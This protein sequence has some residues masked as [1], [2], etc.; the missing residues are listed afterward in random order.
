MPSQK[1]Q[2]GQPNIN[3]TSLFNTRTL[4]LPKNIK[5]LIITIPD[6]A[7]HAPNAVP[8]KRYINQTFLPQ[9]AVI[10][11]G[12]TIVWFSS[13]A[14]HN[15]I[16][17]INDHNNASIFKSG[18]F[19]F[20][21]ATKPVKFNKTGTHTFSDPVNALSKEAGVNGFIMTGTVKVV[22]LSSSGPFVS[23]ITNN[24]KIDTVGADM[25]PAKTV[26]QYI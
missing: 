23:D 19:V 26:D 10:N 21:T 2:E 14:D 6:E 20:N 22:N 3:A 1:Q 16:I 13:D 18:P 9:N 25:V 5:N 11:L 24:S 12:T 8:P 17:N 7:H 15:H 4:V